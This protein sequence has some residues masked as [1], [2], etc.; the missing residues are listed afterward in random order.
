[1]HTSPDAAR[2][3][4]SA[5]GL[6][7]LIAFAMTCARIV[8]AQ[9]VPEPSLHSNEKQPGKRLWP[10]S[11]P[12][13]MPTFSSNDRSRWATVRALA[14]HGTY[15][16]GKRD[17]AVVRASA[18]A[19]LGQ[20]DPV[21]AAMLAGAGHFTRISPA[22]NTGIIFEDGYQTVDKVLHPETLEYYSTKPPILATLLAG[23]YLALKAVTGWTLAEHP[24]RVV[25]TILLLV[26]AVPFAVYLVQLRRIVETWGRTDWARLYVVGA[27]AFATLVSPFLIT[28][29]NHT[30]GTFSVM[31][32]WLALLRV[33]QHRDG[34]RAGAPPWY[35]FVSAG[36]FAAF[37]VCNE[38]PALA[39]AAAV[40]VLLLWWF[41]GRTLLLFV[42]AALVPM[43]AFFA[44]NYLAIGQFRPIQ[45]DFGGRFY[46]YEGSHWRL[47]NEGE[48][49]PGIDWAL[50]HES[51]GEYALHVLVGHHGLF[52]L[53]PIWLLAVAAMLVGLTRR[54]PPPP[55]DVER[56]PAELPW[57]VQPLGL[58]LT[59]VVL[60]FF[61]TQTTNY[62]GWT[63]GL[64]WLMWLT[65]V[66]LTCLLP[67]ADRL[68]RSATGRLVAY[69]C[70]AASV[71]SAHYWLWNPWR[72]P[73]IY[74]LMLACGWPG[75]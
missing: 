44:T 48:R 58:A 41:P 25:Y 52:S 20:L 63:N 23:L 32:A 62:G 54:G 36:F 70:L 75:Y 19:P 12:R 56:P 68:G 39:F 43:V 72:H 29:N 14:D 9:L 67:M 65:P 2:L 38:M 8:S 10:K 49:P 69:V 57:F 17:P 74:D 53:T 4:R 37:A 55:G 16:V 15:V 33:W 59:V 3:A 1:M 13:P 30:L 71:F 45:S 42:P 22:Y 5:C 64:R 51:R 46:R 26:N 6:L 34:S 24:F 11:M 18:V 61:L 66:W 50:Y 7:I 28:L 60:G 27:G 31:F 47:P 21:A 73:W 35:H 40:F